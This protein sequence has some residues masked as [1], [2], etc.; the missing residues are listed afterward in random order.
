M[1]TCR[2]MDDKSRSDITRTLVTL[3]TTKYGPRTGKNHCQQAARQLIL[4]YPFMKDDLG[5]G[6]VSIYIQYIYIFT[7]LFLFIL[8]LLAHAC[9]YDGRECRLFLFIARHL[10][11]PKCKNVLTIGSNS[12]EES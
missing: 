4:K 3:L 11:F 9:L 8:C 6:Y 1:S 12:P 7:Y 5:S 10:G 2:I